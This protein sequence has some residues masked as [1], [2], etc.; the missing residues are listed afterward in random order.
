MDTIRQAEIEAQVRELV[1]L[2]LANIENYKILDSYL[3][4]L[5]PAERVHAL[6]YGMTVSNDRIFKNMMSGS[7]G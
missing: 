4:S 5:Q 2:P 6:Q 1:Q 3:N 7:G